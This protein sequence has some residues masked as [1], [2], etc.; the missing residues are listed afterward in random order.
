M[1]KPTRSAR[2]HFDDFRGSNPKRF[3]SLDLIWRA[4]GCPP[5]D[6]PAHWLALA[7]NL[8]DGLVSYQNE[9]TIDWHGPKEG[10]EATEAVSEYLH[11]RVVWTFAYESA[12]SNAEA[13]W[14]SAGVQAGDNMATDEVV[15]LYAMYLDRQGWAGLVSPKEKPKRPKLEPGDNPILKLPVAKSAGRARVSE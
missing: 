3:A 15:V 5:D 1:I 9:V 7:K 2:Q 8:L 4:V 12:R 6:S 11:W 10:R 13:G 14:D